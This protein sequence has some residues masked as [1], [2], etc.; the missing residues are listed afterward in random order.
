MSVS[1]QR[2][3]WTR[4]AYRLSALK[5]MKLAKPGLYEDG[6]GLRLVITD[7]GT[8]RWAMRVTIDRRRVERGLGVYPDVGLDDAREKAAILRRAAK[9]GRD[10]RADDKQKRRSSTTFSLKP[11]VG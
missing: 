2:K 6:V 11:A 8:K 4:A 10:V 7:K 1:E 9:D 5:V 3:K